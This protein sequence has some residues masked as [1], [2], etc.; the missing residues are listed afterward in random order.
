MKKLL[1]LFAILAIGCAKEETPQLESFNCDC[2]IVR[3][4]NP[5]EGVSEA[6]SLRLCLLSEEVT[7]VRG[8]KYID[9]TVSKADQVSIEQKC[10]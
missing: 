3:A 5:S 7:V 2:E 4:T 6:V 10:N 1:L 8:D 9:M